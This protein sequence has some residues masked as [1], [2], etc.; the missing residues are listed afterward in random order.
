MSIELR[1]RYILAQDEKRAEALA[2]LRIIAPQ[3]LRIEELPELLED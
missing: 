1:E 3:D 2:E